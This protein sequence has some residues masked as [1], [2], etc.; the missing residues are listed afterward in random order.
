MAM[1]FPNPVFSEGFLIDAINHVDK[2]TYGAFGVMLII[3]IA[4]VLFFLMNAFGAQKALTV[5]LFI[6][7]IMGVFFRFMFMTN[8]YVIY[9]GIIFFVIALFMLK[10]SND[11]GI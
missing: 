10:S 7:S 8:D 2:I 4:A 1:L 9:I 11:S 6:S 5:S 3:V